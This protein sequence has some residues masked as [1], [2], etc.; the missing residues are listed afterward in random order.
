MRIFTPF[1]LLFLFFSTVLSAQTTYT[2]NGGDWFN[3]ATW[4]PS[5]IP[6]AADTAIINTGTTT[7]T[8]NVTVGGLYMSA[9]TISGDSNLTV[10]DS[11]S[12]TGGT[13]SFSSASSA[14]KAKFT[15]ASSAKAN[16]NGFCYINRCLVNEGEFYF[17]G[18]SLG[19]GNTYKAYF[20]NYGTIHDE[21]NENGNI[22]GKFGDWFVNYGRSEEHTSEL[23]SH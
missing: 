22:S 8:D 19:F 21:S 14:L 18:K 7:I 2:S 10:T 16:V 5:G 23:Q 9:G 20:Y 4:T 17:L 6:G 15:I 3:A 12:W 1:L 13:I 11:L